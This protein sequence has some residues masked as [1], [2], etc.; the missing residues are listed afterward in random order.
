MR[1]LNIQKYEI[2]QIKLYLENEW[3]FYL[4]STLL[5]IIIKI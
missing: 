5:I 1:N 3:N 4:Y 2:F